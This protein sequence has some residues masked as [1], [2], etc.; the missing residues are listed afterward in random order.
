ML[1]C[2]CLKSARS[3][4]QKSGEDLVAL[5][6]KGEIFFSYSP[7]IM[8]GQRQRH[9]VKTYVNIRLMIYFQCLLGDAT[10]KIYARHESFKFERSANGLRVFRPTRNGFQV[11]LDLTGG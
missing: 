3:G 4:R 5:P 10:H 11:K 9:L 1:V 8:R 7:F 6:G 2:F